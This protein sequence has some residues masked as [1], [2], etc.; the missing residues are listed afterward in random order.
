MLNI[1]DAA[2]ENT[3][4]MYNIRDVA[5]K[6]CVCDDGLKKRKTGHEIDL[7]YITNT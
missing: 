4:A 3:S 7:I 1:R 2:T 5:L 6:K